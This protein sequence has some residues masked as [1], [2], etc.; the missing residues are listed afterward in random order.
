MNIRT[1]NELGDIR[2]KFILLRDDFNVQIKN[3]KIIDAFRIDQSMPTINWLRKSGAR[4]AICA[5]LG[6]P[7]GTFNPEYTLRPVADY[8]KIPLISDCLD[9]SFMD[10]MQDG[11]VV[12]LENVR[13]YMEEEENDL[14]FAKK[15]ASGFDI[16]INDAFAV[17]HRA[18][19]STQGITKFLPSYAGK[20]LSDEIEKL[21][22]IMENPIRPLIGIIGGG[23]L[24]TK[25]NILESLANRCDTLII[26]GGLG[27]AFA[28][29]SG[30]Y[31]W[32]DDLYKSEYK[33]VIKKILETAKNKGCKIIIPIDKGTGLQLAETAK[34]TDKLLSNISENDVIMDDGP[35]SV[36]QYKQVIDDAKTLVWNGTLGKSEWG[37]I[38]G[39]STFEMIRYI[40]KRTKDGKLI[41]IIGG[42]DSVTATEVTDTK[43]DMTYIST[44]GGAFLEFIEG[45]NL[46]GISALKKK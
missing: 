17:S 2:G 9:K 15:L 31:N 29:S 35:L 32:T 21:T 16:F 34:R 11:D 19:A 44:G 7:G 46:P 24:D 12:L 23:K 30:Q 18:H 42:G 10:K 39:R 8:L 14:E 37:D 5:H 25:I 4:V 40:A 36:E 33:P 22:L 41:S 27:T 26:G 1:I 45:K 6:R 20:L 38:W 43:Q 28:L 3:G 13:F